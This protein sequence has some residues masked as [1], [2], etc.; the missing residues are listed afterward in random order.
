MKN[1]SQVNQKINKSA[2]GNLEDNEKLNN[3]V[4]QAIII[5]VVTH[6]CY[7][8]ETFS[9]CQMQMFH[10]E[11]LVEIQGIK[12]QKRFSLFTSNGQ[13]NSLK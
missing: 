7:V 9:K 1:I 13:I 3:L 5:E 8:K 6:R 11:A 4:L 12:P 10:G 2:L